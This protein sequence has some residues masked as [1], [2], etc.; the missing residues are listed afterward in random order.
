[1]KVRSITSCPGNTSVRCLKSSPATPGNRMVGST[2]TSKTLQPSRR[3]VVHHGLRIM[4]VHVRQLI[5]LV[6]D[7]DEDRIFGTKK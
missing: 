1:M 5:G 3:R 4:A 7:H 6:V 2:R